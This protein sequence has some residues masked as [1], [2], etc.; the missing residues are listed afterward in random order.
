MLDLVRRRSFGQS[1][2]RRHEK[3]NDKNR[4]NNSTK[5]MQ[6]ISSGAYPFRAC[7]NGE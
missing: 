2:D 1:D 5:G 4:S 7:G 3:R 6:G